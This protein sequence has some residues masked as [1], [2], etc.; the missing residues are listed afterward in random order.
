MNKTGNQAILARSDIDISFES[1]HCFIDSP[2][3]KYADVEI[4]SGFVLKQLRTFGSNIRSAASTFCL[5][6]TYISV[7][8]KPDENLW[9]NR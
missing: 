3:F 8:H 7:F 4:V 6:R 9:L 1:K 5:S 2:I